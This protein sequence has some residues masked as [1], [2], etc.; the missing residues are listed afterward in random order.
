MAVRA[1]NRQMIPAFAIE[2]VCCS[3]AS[4]RITFVLSNNFSNSFIQQIPLSDKT[5]A[6]DSKI[7]S[8]DSGFL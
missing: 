6:P 7:G 2:I 4:W 8:L 1:F 5:K 3:I